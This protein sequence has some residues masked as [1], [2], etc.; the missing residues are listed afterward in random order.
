MLPAELPTAFENVGLNENTSEQDRYGLT[1]LSTPPDELVGG[2]GR[3]ETIG[4][5][6]AIPAS[7][8]EPDSGFEATS[9][10]DVTLPDGTE[11]ELNY[12]EPAVEGAM[13]GPQW[14][15]T[16]TRDDYHYSLIMQDYGKEKVEQALST[17]VEVE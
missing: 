3:Y 15:G 2:W 14:E 9:T 8:Y 5:L 11:A 17:M 12:M 16:F 10:E 1:F 7:E 13:Y 4:S 6:E